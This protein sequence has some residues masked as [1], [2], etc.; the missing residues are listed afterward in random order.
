M[1][2][3]TVIDFPIMD[4]A[5]FADLI[6]DHHRGLLA[7]AIA[8]VKSEAAARDLVQ[9]ASVAA[10]QSLAK[11]DVTRDFGTWM[12]GI[13][14]NKWREYCRRQ[15]RE[16]PLDEETLSRLEQ[17]FERSP[18]DSDLFA[19][20]AEC[21]SKLPGPMAEAVRLTYD[22]GR[23]SDDAAKVL[24][25]TAAALRKRLERAREALR[26]CLSRNA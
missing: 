7:Y 20:L 16:I 14:R 17:P 11:F 24:S 23:T 1:Q 13:V 12:R 2:A 25:T 10:W 18:D 19:R 8:L 26:L 3:A 21:R 22:E 6:R 4:R 15:S 5:R 9:E